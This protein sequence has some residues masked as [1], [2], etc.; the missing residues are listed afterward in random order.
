MA[1]PAT[2]E[3]GLAGTGPGVQFVIVRP[4]TITCAVPTGRYREKQ[5]TIL[6]IAD[7]Y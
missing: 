3:I 6:S 1:Q 4:L 7:C 5:L 2:L